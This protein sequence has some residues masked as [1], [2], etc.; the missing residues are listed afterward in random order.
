MLSLTLNGSTMATSKQVVIDT[1]MLVALVDAH[2]ALH[3]RAQALGEAL[4]A[5][6]GLLVYYDVVINEAISVLARCAQEQRRTHQ[7]TDLLDGLLHQ[8]PT[9]VIVWL[10]SETQHLYSQMIDLVRTTSGALN[11]HDALIA[12]GCR[13]L[14]VEILASFDPDFD[15]LDW[16]TRVSTPE[17]VTAAFEQASSDETH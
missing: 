12:L 13:L 10:S 8:V 7:F 16:L 9:E 4:A 14:G 5:Q 15:Q 17:S 3:T 1:N 11:F 6:E 2:D